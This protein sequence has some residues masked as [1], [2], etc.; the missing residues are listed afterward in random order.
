MSEII[1]TGIERTLEVIKNPSERI[2]SGEIPS[3][4]LR[5]NPLPQVGDAHAH[6]SESVLHKTTE[7]L[8]PKDNIWAGCGYTPGQIEGGSTETISG[9]DRARGVVAKKISQ[10]PVT[11]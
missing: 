2:P 4:E 11:E 9:G 10:V 8:P 5:E 6:T 3:V 7:I 1:S